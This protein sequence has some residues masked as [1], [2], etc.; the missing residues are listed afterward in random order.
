MIK[1]CCS[2]LT[3][4][5]HTLIYICP[6][7]Y[8]KSLKRE[9]D[10][11]RYEQNKDLILQRLRE[12]R[13]QNKTTAVLSGEHNQPDTPISSIFPTGQNTVTMATDESTVIQISITPTLE[14]FPN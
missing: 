2:H 3:C 5:V 9:R 12:T 7:E 8:K 10:N 4:T 14:G 6:T 11:A 1:N 13:R